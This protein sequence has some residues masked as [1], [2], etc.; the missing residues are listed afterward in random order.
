MTWVKVCGIRCE[1]DLE[2]A[3]EAGAD[4]VGLVLADVSPRRVGLEVAARLVRRAEIETVLVTVDATPARV[5]EWLDLTGASGVQPHGDHSAEAAAAARRAGRLVLRPVPVGE[6]VALDHVPEGEVP[7]LD[8]ADSQR[9]GGTGRSFDWSLVEGIASRRW[10]LAGGLRPDTVGEAVRR[11][12]PW[13][14][15]A[16]SGLESEPGRKD[17]ELIM[18]FVAEAKQA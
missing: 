13:G 18:R 3:Q 6:R 2:A 8:T 11:L 4:A 16:S 15:D 5:L 1:A 7:L 17:R 12:R 9:H 10:V 14:V